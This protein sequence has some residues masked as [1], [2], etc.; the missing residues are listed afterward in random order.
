[1]QNN[2]SQEASFSPATTFRATVVVADWDAHID[3]H[4]GL[5][6]GETRRVAHMT[7]SQT[8]CRGQAGDRRTQPVADRRSRGLRLATTTTS[9]C[10]LRRVTLEAFSLGL[11]FGAAEGGI[12]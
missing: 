8:A 6:A 2:L 11:W 9:C 12:G 5:T 4:G 1:M 7:T 3:T 10:E